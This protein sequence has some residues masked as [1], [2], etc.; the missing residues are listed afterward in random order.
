MTPHI[1]SRIWINGKEI[2]YC[3]L[4]GPPKSPLLEQD[5]RSKAILLL[6]S[7]SAFHFASA[8]YSPDGFR[9][10]VEKINNW[11][12]RFVKHDLELLIKKLIKKLPS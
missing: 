2:V 3:E 9:I 11:E 7:L 12:Y 1:C 6:E 4:C 8:G 10:N 5:L